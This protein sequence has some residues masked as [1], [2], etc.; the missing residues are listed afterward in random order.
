MLL[1]DA[2]VRLD[3]ITMGHFNIGAILLPQG[4]CSG[5]FKSCDQGGWRMLVTPT[6]SIAGLKQTTA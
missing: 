6:A 5:S 4:L 1:E 2:I 3:G